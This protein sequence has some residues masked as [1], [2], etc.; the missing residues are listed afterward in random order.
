MFYAKRV[1]KLGRSRTDLGPSREN[2]TG[3]KRLIK[4]KTD[5]QPLPLLP[6]NS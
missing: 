1:G 5:T 3:K 4:G 6:V 2:K